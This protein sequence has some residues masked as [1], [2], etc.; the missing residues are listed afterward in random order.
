ML[1][2]VSWTNTLFLLESSKIGREKKHLYDIS[3]LLTQRGIN[4]TRCRNFTEQLTQ[5][6]QLAYGYIFNFSSLGN[7]NPPREKRE[8]LFQGAWD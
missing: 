7:K 5:R 1:I 6:Y 4:Q 8:C 2:N 3:L